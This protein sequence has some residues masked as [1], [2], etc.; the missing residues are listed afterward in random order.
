MLVSEGSEAVQISPVDEASDKYV[1]LK[2]E[3]AIV[4]LISKEFMLG[5]WFYSLSLL[6]MSFYLGTVFVELEGE[7]DCSTNILFQANLNPW[8]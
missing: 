4:Q 1:P 8:Y 5:T 6:A 2:K 3:T 7:E